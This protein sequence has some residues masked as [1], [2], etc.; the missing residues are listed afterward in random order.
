MRL[1]DVLGCDAALR[2]STRLVGVQG[3]DAVMRHLKAG[4]PLSEAQG[5]LAYASELLVRLSIP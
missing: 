1:V 4:H 5:K 3:R 2:G